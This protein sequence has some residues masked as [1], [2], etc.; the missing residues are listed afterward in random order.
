M[1][2]DIYEG[3]FPLKFSSITSSS[4]IVSTSTISPFFILSSTF[5]GLESISFN[6]IAYL[7]MPRI[8]AAVIM[9]PYLVII[10]DIFGMIGGLV[11][12]TA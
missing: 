3:D 8:V 9:F 6:P 2:I 4:E 10:G 1:S 12:S 5:P 11:A 7:I